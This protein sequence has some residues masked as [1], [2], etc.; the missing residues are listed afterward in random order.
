VD[1]LAGVLLIRVTLPPFDKYNLFQ[2]ANRCSIFS[3]T[4]SQICLALKEG[5]NGRPRYFTGKVATP[6]PKIQANKSTCST[7][8]TRIN[9]DLA[10]LTF[11]PEAASNNKNK[12]RK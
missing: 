5:P 4:P 9:V 1:K 12:L 6:L 8:P 10:K 2:L 7:F 3:I 11:K